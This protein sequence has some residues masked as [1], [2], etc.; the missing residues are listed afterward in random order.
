MQDEEENIDAE[1]AAERVNDE[2]SV[3]SINEEY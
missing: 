2:E 1:N 3:A